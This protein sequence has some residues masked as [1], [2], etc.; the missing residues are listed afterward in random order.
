M[1][2]RSNLEH[3]TTLSTLSHEVWDGLGVDRAVFLDPTVVSACLAGF[4]SSMI[5]TLRHALNGDP[6]GS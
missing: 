2:L 5:C 3:L 4:S 1:L 6:P